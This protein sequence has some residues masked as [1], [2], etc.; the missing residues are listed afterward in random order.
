MRNHKDKKLIR[1][2]FVALLIVL[3]T[4]LLS[5]NTIPHK[6]TSI[7][8]VSEKSAAYHIS[9][10]AV[11]TGCVLESHCSDIRLSAMAGQP[12]IT[13]TSDS[14]C[15]LFSGF[16]TPM[17]GTVVSIDDMHLSLPDNY[18]LSQN[19]PNPFNPITTIHYS[20]PLRSQVTLTIFNLLGKKV[21]LLV[22]QVQTAEYHTIQWDSR[23]DQG[24][25]LGSG[26][27]FYRIV[28]VPIGESFGLKSGMFTQCH[29]MLL[30]K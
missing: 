25:E 9:W 24:N 6:R 4:P 22:D 20:L 7:E 26:Y 13:E 19:Y 3:T 27:Y 16:W 10:S 30:L 11:N 21:R 14:N 17:H 18:S 23:D 1:L 15:C 12:I 5:L 2:I 28:A 29:K 8:Q